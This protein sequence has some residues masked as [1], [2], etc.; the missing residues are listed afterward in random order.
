[1]AL[2][3]QLRKDR[4]QAMKDK[5]RVAKD[6]LGVALGEAQLAEARQGK[7]EDTQ[8]QKIIRKIIS[9][10]EEVMKIKADE[11]LTKENEILEEFLPQMW[12][13]EQITLHLQSVDGMEELL[14]T[15]KSSGQAT[16]I[17]MKAL[18]C[19]D[20]SVD[21]KIVSKVVSQMRDA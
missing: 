10:N 5:N 20:A 19:A 1:M 7:I 9:S 8:V 15:A 2:M 11:K 21:G 16:G 3:E 12:T 14:K 4:I 6:I 18:K 17:A 13:E